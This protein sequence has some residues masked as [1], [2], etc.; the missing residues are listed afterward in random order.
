MAVK[1]VGRRIEV[2]EE[3]RLELERIV[4]ASSSEVRLV[5]RARMCWL[6]RRG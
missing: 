4:R 2:S 6:R 3:D 1:G 5:E